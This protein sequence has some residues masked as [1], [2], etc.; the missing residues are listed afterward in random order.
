MK[1]C[2]RLITVL[3]L[4]SGG[5]TAN[6]QIV[7]RNAQFRLPADYNFAFYNEYPEA[8]RSFYAA[9]FAHFSVYEALLNEGPD[10]VNEIQRLEEQIRYYVANPPRLEP[11]A[12]I[13]APNWSKIAYHTG[14]AMD[15]THMLH[16]QLYDLLADD[17]L[18][19]KKAA[20]QR[21]ISYY[22]ANSRAAFS[23]RGYGHAVM[24]A[25]AS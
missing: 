9:H 13:I 6:G 16:S 20:G 1:K 5:Q 22:L 18:P 15:W 14:Q 23:T 8:A 12:D 3:G 17:R 2:L 21:A 19:D 10:A 7:Q 11:P 24:L 4:C 25:S